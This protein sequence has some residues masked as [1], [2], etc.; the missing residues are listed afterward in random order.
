MGAKSSQNVGGCAVLGGMV[1]D[2]LLDKLAFEQRMRQENFKYL[3]GRGHRKCKGPEAGFYL[4]CE[5]QR[6]GQCGEAE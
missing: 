2:G 3:S 5:E 6:R 4:T 1:R